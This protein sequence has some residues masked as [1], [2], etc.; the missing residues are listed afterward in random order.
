[1]IPATTYARYDQ[2]VIFKIRKEN[3]NAWLKICF[4]FT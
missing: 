1:M 4:D 3:I 2:N